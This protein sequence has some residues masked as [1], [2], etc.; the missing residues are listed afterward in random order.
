MRPHYW[1]RRVVLSGMVGFYRVALHPRLP[2]KVARVVLDSAAHIQ[3]LPAGSVVRRVEL[4]GQQAERITV[5][6]TQRPRAVIYLHGGGFTIGSM[7]TH[8]SAVAYLAR[9]SGAVAYSLDY[10]LAPEH[11]YPAGLDDAVNAFLDLV[12][13]GLAPEHIALSGD[14]AGGGMAVAAARR[15]VDEHGVRPGALALF[16][17]WV[18][19]TDETTRKRDLVVSAAWA[20][21]NGTIYVAGAD[22]HLPGISPALGNLA[23]LPPMWVLTTKPELLHDQI[24]RFVEAVRAAG[25]DV[26]LSE[27]ANLW[28][29]G[30]TQVSMVREA[31][32]VIHAAGV[33][34]R[35]TL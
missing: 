29:S 31:G 34:L 10:R 21:A 18:D 5:G 1:P 2:I 25:G 9:E 17:P 16:S 24:I 19:L 8:R 28:H 15:L 11:P 22:P 33:Y 20:K 26:S 35:R 30:H 6:A 14:S 4:G 23:D 12:A 27:H 3:T 13:R 7:G 32:D